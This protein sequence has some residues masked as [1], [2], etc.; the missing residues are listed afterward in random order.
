MID[1]EMYKIR[2]SKHFVLKWMRKWDWDIHSIRKALEQANIKKVGKIKYEAYIKTKK[3]KKVVF[4]IYEDYKEI[5]I[6][7]GAEG[8]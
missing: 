4:V 7:T 5:F 1:F 3:S 6:I 2:P 8:K